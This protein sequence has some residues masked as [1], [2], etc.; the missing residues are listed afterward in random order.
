MACYC[1]DLCRGI[2]LCLSSWQAWRSQIAMFVL[3]L[4]GKGKIANGYLSHSCLMLASGCVWS[5]PAKAK[6][7]AGT[8]EYSDADGVLFG[9]IADIDDLVSF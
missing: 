8:V 6:E 7:Y 9:G 1:R 3:C 2:C 4:S 5:A